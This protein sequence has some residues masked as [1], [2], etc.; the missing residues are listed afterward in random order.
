MLTLRE[1]RPSAFHSWYVRQGKSLLDFCAATLLLLILSPLL[2]VLALI[3]RL[4]LGRG[5]IFTQLRAGLHGEPFPCYKFRTMKPE[6]RLASR[7]YSGPERRSGLPSPDD[8][9][10]TRVGTILRRYGLDE[11]PQLI[12]VL[13]GHMSIVGPRPEI[14]DIA[15]H[16]IV[17]NNSALASNLV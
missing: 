17:C 3:V 15:S 14:L 6:R 5:V 13:Q 4:S 7:P 1:P 2:I 16:T 9:R 11:L 8:P 12:N 10:H